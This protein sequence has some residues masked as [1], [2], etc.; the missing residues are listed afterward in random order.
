MAIINHKCEFRVPY[1]D[2]DKMGIV[3]HTNYIKYFEIGRTELLRSK[4][5]AYQH[6]EEMGYY[7]PLLAANAEYIQSALYDDIITIE[8]EVDSNFPVRFT[9]FYKIFRNDT[10]LCTGSTKHC[11]MHI[12][13][14]KPSRP[15]KF[16]LDFVN[17]LS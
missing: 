5:M 3:Y 11:F 1:Y 4:G 13:S 12:E 15:P 10:L 9:F 17:T 14:M 7:L 16:F 8:T 2:T 6:I